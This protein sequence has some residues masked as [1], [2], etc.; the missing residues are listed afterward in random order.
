MSSKDETHN[1]PSLLERESTGGDIASGGLSFQEAIVLSYL[2]MW[3]AKNSFASFSYEMMGDSEAKFFTPECEVIELYEMK[4]QTVTPNLFWNEID[5]FRRLD[6]GC[7]DTYRHFYFMCTGLSTKLRPLENMLQRIRGANPLEN[8]PFYPRQAAVPVNSERAFV[9]KVINLKKDK[10]TAQFILNRVTIKSELGGYTDR[11]KALFLDNF[12]KHFPEYDELSGRELDQVYG[13]V[14]ELV[15]ANRAKTI[16]RRQLV[17]AIRK[18]EHP[19][20]LPPLQ[21]V[22]LHTSH[23]PN[24]PYHGKGILMEWN[25]FFAGDKRIYPE[26]KRWNGEL[27]QGLERTLDWILTNHLCH[28]ILLSGHRCLSANLAVG[29]VFS[30][31]SGTVVIIDQRGTMWAT[32]AHAG[33]ETPGY[34]ME[35]TFSEGTGTHLVVSVGIMRR[36]GDQVNAALSVQGLDDAPHLR[37]HG[38]EAII[39]ADHANRVVGIIKRFLAETIQTT[40]SK[41]VDL[42]YAGPATLAVFL[43]HRLNAVTPIHCYEWVG[44][45]RYVPTCTLFRSG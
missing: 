39:S 38:E 7:P 30:A 18:V 17:H 42:F 32:D 44:E 40:H 25:D 9:E 10:E 43:G 20:R 13:R 11:A 23:N 21:P 29:A 1:S 27:L 31:V 19:E 24:I 5:R 28:H 33:P 4:E 8:E 34:N 12:R 16:T 26:P 15:R 22:E 41:D 36:I 6:E 3:L 14:I 45:G 2:P 35:R 37:L